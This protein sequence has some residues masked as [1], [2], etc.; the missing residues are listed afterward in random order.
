MDSSERP[1]G[2]PWPK[3]LGAPFGVL[4]ALL[5]GLALLNLVAGR[6]ELGVT[7]V[8][9]GTLLLPL[10]VVPG[11]LRD[12]YVDFFVERAGFEERRRARPQEPW[13]SRSEWAQGKIASRL[14]LLAFVL[15]WGFAYVWISLTTIGMIAMLKDPRDVGPKLAVLAVFLLAGAAIVA[16]AVRMTTHRRRYQGSVLEL[17][18]L[19]GV[20]GG[21]LT[22]WVSC[23]RGLPPDAEFLI[24]LVCV[25]YV[26]RTR[27]TGNQRWIERTVL[28]RDQHRVDRPTSLSVPVSFSVPYDLPESDPD[29]WARERHYW[30][31][32]V[33]A[34]SANYA[35]LFEVPIFRTSASDAAQ[36]QS[37]VDRQAALKPPSSRIDV[38]MASD[39][40]IVVRYPSIPG[41]MAWLL[42]G[43]VI[44]ALA[45]PVQGSILTGLPLA[46]VQ[47][48]AW[49]L[50][51]GL[52][53]IVM[54]ALLT[55]PS[56]VKAAPDVVRI[57]RGRGP[58]VW[59]RRVAVAE[60][61]D[62]T[63]STSKVEPPTFTVEL[64]TRGGRTREVSPPLT[65]VDEAKWLAF[66]L[67]TAIGI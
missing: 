16:G 22:G 67:R 29:R 3:I 50:G 65:E 12:A 41:L 66:E 8:V 19:P 13:L 6:T 14:P 30:E 15:T 40:G 63:F 28:W 34:P 26:R 58:F 55:T 39:G 21:R 23:D 62:V 57:R 45:R 43:P 25:H 18:T 17:D 32:Q 52:T 37:K 9:F 35:A 27:T 7:L 49:I 20:L 2:D 4:G 5:L 61:A 24:S 31:L 1:G 10:T 44:V 47:R 53:G 64:R 56:R 38:G 48:W 60:I 54:L 59:T 11:L 33:T 36:V 46:S 51:S 42:A